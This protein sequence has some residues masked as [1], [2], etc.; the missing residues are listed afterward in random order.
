[1][2]T[3]G[4]WPATWWAKDYWIDNYWPDYGA[5]V[6]TPYPLFLALSAETE[7]EMA[8]STETEYGMELSV[9]SGG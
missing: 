8:L 3:A 9:T 2:L 6:A 7:Y 5:G 4:F 1:M